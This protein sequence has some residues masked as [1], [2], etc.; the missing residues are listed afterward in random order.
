MNTSIEKYF[1]RMIENLKNKQ[2][3]LI[4]MSDLT[5]AQAG[6][7]KSDTLPV[8]QKLIDEKQIRI[9]AIDKLDEEFSVYMGRLKSTAGVNSL[10]ELDVS[11]Y[12]AAAQL[13]GI[14]TEILGLIKK[15]SEIEKLNS[16]KS[17][18]LLNELGGEIKKI[19]Q[20][21]K[22]NKAYSPG[23]VSLPSYFVDK[24]K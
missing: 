1:D 15:I 9:D 21:K 24:K 23:P 7:I 10:E 5:Q 3:L 17:K 22:V 19:N 20:G 2:K 4:E 18:E 12:P 13:K 11:T 6:V 14:T 8:L 16:S